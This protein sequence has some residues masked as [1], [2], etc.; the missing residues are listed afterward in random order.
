MPDHKG[1]SLIELMVAVAIIAIIATIAVPSFSALLQN[2]RLSSA[3]NSV[4][5]A[6]QTA[7]SEAATLRSTIKVCAA[8][9]AQTACGNSTDWKSGVLIMRGSTLLR[10]V[11][12]AQKGV[13]VAASTQEVAYLGNGTTSAATVTLTSESG[14]TTTILVN[15]IG[16]ACIEGESGKCKQ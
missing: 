3:T 1:F 7:R 12:S 4:L 10:V 15:T 16:Q 8:N 13:S 2:S 9:A 6:L 5:G 11:P 14:R